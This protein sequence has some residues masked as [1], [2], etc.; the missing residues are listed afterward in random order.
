VSLRTRLIGLLSG[1][2]LLVTLA[3]TLGGM[4]IL[5]RRVE[6]SVMA[7]AQAESK[8]IAYSLEDYL[9]S[10]RSDDEVKEKL[11]SLR[12]HHHLVARLAVSLVSEEGERVDLVLPPGGDVE[13]SHSA[14]ARHPRGERAL[15]YEGRIALSDHGDSLRP[16]A[17]RGTEPLWRIE[18]RGPSS[19]WSRYVPVVPPPRSRAISTREDQDTCRPQ[20]C[21]TTHVSLDPIGPQRGAV[22]VTVVVDRYSTVLR[23]QLRISAVTTLLALLFLLLF[24]AWTVNRVVV[25]PVS[26]M[27]QAMHEVEQGNLMR[28][29][30]A[31]RHDEIGN[32][33]RGF[34][35]MLDR[36]A[37]ADEEIRALNSRLADDIAVATRDLQHKNEALNQLNRLMVQT[38]RELGDKERLAALGQLAAQLAHEIGTPLASVSGHLQLATYGRDV[39]PALRERLQLASGELQRVSKIIRDYLDQ[40]RTAKPTLQPTDLR[41]VVEEAVRV[42]GSAAR[43]PGLRVFTEFESG[44]AEI[45][46]DPGLVRQILINL[47]TNAMDATAARMAGEGADLQPLSS[48]RVVVSVRPV[49]EDEVDLSV[50][51]D[52]TGIAPE[53]LARIFEP[54]YTTKGRGK[55]T[56]LGLSICRE[57]VRTLGGKLHVESGPGRGSTFSILLP[58]R[59][60]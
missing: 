1:L 13:V 21:L 35:A 39:P 59:R 44:V 55:G 10:E 22:D 2:L 31:R 52:G 18:D 14:R 51:D 38:Q 33:G 43:R 34:N 45:E 36:L 4:Y 8:D 16:P 46:T 19:R 56:G 7:D 28:R 58:R 20:R 17:L 15:L 29:V 48:G 27:A 42:A 25:R 49:G 50:K 32:L 24:T 54:F 3:S 9:Q 23:D 12:R 47:L 53:D 30:D 6:T 11:E 26:E 60:S 5:R 57:L 37:Q 40:T 41:R